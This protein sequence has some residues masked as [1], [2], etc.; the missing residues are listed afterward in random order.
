[1]WESLVGIRHRGCPISDTSD[2]LPNITIQNVSRTNIPD[3][4]GRRLL[5]IRGDGE[6][7]NRF[8]E[9]C[10]AHDQI[11]DV[12]CISGTEGTDAYYTIDIEYKTENPSILSI[13]NSRGIFYHGSILVQSGIEHWL[14]YTSEKKAIQKLIEEIESYENSVSV[15]RT[16]DLGEL[17]HIQSIE[18]GLVLSELTNQQQRT[19]RAALE[20]GYYENDSD[21]VVEDIADELDRHETTTW[22]HLKKAE[23]SILT[24]IG[25]RLFSSRTIDTL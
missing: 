6:E 18:Y 5:Y 20:M 9:T 7:V 13:F 17:G 10:L 16:V 11:V 3:G 4:F 23:N 22:E 24:N 25:N 15:Y 2:S 12:E 14:L 1:M 8:E 21:T 19:F